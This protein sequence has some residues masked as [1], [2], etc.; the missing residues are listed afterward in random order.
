MQYPFTLEHNDYLT[1]LLYST[2][3]SRKV[4]KRRSLNKII[5]VTIYLLTAL[6]LYNINGP[7]AA[8]LF[9]LLCLPLYFFYNTFERKQYLKHFTKLINTHFKDSIGKP[10][11]IELGDKSFHVVDD[12]DNWYAYEDIQE[13][14]EIDSLVIV[15]L[16][17]GAAILIPKERIPNAS[18][19]VETLHQEAAARNIPERKDLDW[20]WK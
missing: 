12:E 19:L 4:Q 20:K 11:S 3:Q 17:N 16:K 15:Q 7:W 8:G 1:Y 18:S 2:S 14:I 5:L 6:F 10:S 9:L 13:I